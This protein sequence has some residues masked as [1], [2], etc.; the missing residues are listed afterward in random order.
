MENFQKCF[1]SMFDL[2]AINKK[3]KKQ[4]IKLNHVDDKSLKT[5]ETFQIQKYI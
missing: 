2:L 3:K 1:R 4:N 5:K